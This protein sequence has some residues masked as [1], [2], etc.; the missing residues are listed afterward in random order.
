MNHIQYI[1]R[2]N[3]FAY[4]D[5]WFQTGSPEAGRIHTIYDDKAEAELAFKELIVEALYAEEEL[6]NYDIGNGYASDE[7]YEKL[8]KFIK[9]K[10]GEDFEIDDEL[11]ELSLDDAFQFAQISG[12]MHYQL[13][14]IDSQ[15]PIYI[16]WSNQEQDYL[17]SENYNVFD[18]IDENFST[19][20][21]FE[22]YIFEN[23]FNEQVFDQALENISESP[24][25]L[26]NLILGIPAVVYAEDRHSIV[27]IDW[28][29]ISFSQ[30]KSI[31]ALLK[32]P[33]FEVQQINVEQLNTITNGE[34]NE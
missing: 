26:K 18:S 27:N 32:Q 30:L 25:I 11:P 3:D 16:L 5:E 13:L 29:D 15:K 6:S 24:E 12:V 20:D 4:N 14:E 17:R 8:E 33:I 23:D 9:E 2:H 7:T 21:D 22:L 10:T 1:I 31:N 34:S 19:L 28:E